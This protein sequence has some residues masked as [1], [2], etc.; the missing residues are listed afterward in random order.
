MNNPLKIIYKYKN[1]NNRIQYFIYI[2]IGSMIPDKILDILNSIKNKNFFDTLMFLSKKHFDSLIEYYGKNWYNFFFTTE[3]LKYSFNKIINTTSKKRSII[4]KFGDIWY[5]ININKNVTSKRTY[6]FA[7]KYYDYMVERKKIKNIIN[8]QNNNFTTYSQ[9]G[10]TVIT[11]QNIDNKIDEENEDNVDTINNIEDLEDEV[12]EE[13][14]ID[15]LTELYSM[16]QVN[17]DKEIQKTSKLISEAINDKSWEKKITDLSLKFSKK[18]EEINFD[19][20]LSDVYEK[21]YITDQYIFFDDTINI[22]KKKLATVIPISEKFGDNIKLL[23]E[24]QYLWINYN[25]NNTNDNIMLGQKWIRRNELLKI[26]IEPNNSLKAYENLS[27]NLGYLRDSF[28]IK[29]KR[30]DD[31]HKILS[32]YQEYISNNEIYMI[33]IL[34]ELGLNYNS[35]SEKKKIYLKFILIFIFHLYH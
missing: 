11:D 18:K 10:G 23:P 26:D 15:E 2:L 22:I 19:E 4:N 28:G 27:N 7:N 33:D 14:D 21:I 25:L 9:T 35:E 17:K 29:I 34:N 20:N 16:E 31:E 3:H 13:F 5:K 30:E 1:N 6:S 32:D 12:I 24:Y 8:V